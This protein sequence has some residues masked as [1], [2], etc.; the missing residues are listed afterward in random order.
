MEPEGSAQPGRCCLHLLRF[1]EIEEFPDDVVDF[2]DILGGYAIGRCQA[3]CRPCD[4]E[5][6]QVPLC[7]EDV[8]ETDDATLFDD[9]GFLVSV[10]N[11]HAS[12]VLSR[13][14]DGRAC[15]GE[16]CSHA[17]AW[18]WLGWEGGGERGELR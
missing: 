4:G 12:A 6:V 5:T 11:K 10:C 7:V 2:S 3:L 14:V 18:G 17:G 15:T 9:K 1:A 16:G 8:E 13:A